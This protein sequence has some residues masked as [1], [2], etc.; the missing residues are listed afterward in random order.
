M[1]RAIVSLS[2]A[3]PN[4]PLKPVWVG[5]DSDAL[6]LLRGVP[7]GFSARLYLTKAGASAAVYF[8]SSDCTSGER[9]VHVGGAN[10][11]VAGPGGRY[12]VRI[13]DQEGRTYWCGVGL[14][15]VLPAAGGGSVTGGAGNA[16]DT[17]IRNPATGLYHR[18]RAEINA[19]GDITST[20]EQEGTSLA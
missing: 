10:F 7:A 20:V 5:A 8:D 9:C 2:P 14:L 6:I 12:E 11:P 3:T 17:Y 16:M 1:Y 18:V 19:D 13:A 4:M 15:T